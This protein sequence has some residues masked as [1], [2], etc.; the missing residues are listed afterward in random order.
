[1]D[2]WDTDPVGQDVTGETAYNVTF[3][4]GTYNVTLPGSV[5]GPDSATY[6]SDLTFIPAAS[7]EIITNVTAKIGNDSITVDKNPNGSYTIAGSQITGDITIEVTSVTGTLEEI[8]Y[9]DYAALE[10]GTKIVVVRTAQLDD[11]NKYTMTGGVG[12]LYW[13]GKYNAYVAIVDKDLTEAQL[14]SM[15]VRFEGATTEISYSGDINGSGTTTAADAG[16]VNDILHRVTLNY[17]P[18]A[19]MR[20]ELD[21]SGDKKV[22]TTDIQTVLEKAVKLET[23]GTSTGSGGGSG[24]TAT[25]SGA[26]IGG[27]GSATTITSE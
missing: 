13:S 21:V 10:S 4:E 3:K 26:G 23:T 15:L 11:G 27:A 18:N 5:S 12:D 14:A 17:T 24:S 25:N 1:M 6:K 7:G 9:D 20:L 2:T 22:T 16:I 8:S 19:K